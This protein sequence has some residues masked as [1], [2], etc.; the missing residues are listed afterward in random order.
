MNAS[1]LWCR[2]KGRN[3]QIL[4]SNC[5]LTTLDTIQ[6]WIRTNNVNKENWQLFRV[7]ARACVC[8]LVLGKFEI[9]GAEKFLSYPSN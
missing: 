1:V 7:C 4:D 5:G 6:C 3:G 9:F 2:Y 8:G